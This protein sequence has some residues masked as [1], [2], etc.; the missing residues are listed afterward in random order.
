MGYWELEEGKDCVQKTWITTKVAT[1]MG[2]V[3]SAIHIALFRPETALEGLTRAANST[4]TM[5]SLGAVFGLATCLTAH[6]RDAP[7]D[8]KNYFVGG[9]ASG[10]IL[11]ARSH[12]VAVGTGACVALGTLAMFTKVGKMEGWRMSGAPKL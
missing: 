2:L 3:G 12:S 8:P 11:G 1:T 5:A 6:A 10:A 9:C 7:E 4:V